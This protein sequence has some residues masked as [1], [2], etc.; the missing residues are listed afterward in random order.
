M[1]AKCHVIGEPPRYKPRTDSHRDHPSATTAGALVMIRR[2]REP[3]RFRA[4]GRAQVR[5]HGLLEHFE[6]GWQRY[7]LVENI[8]LGGARVAVDEPLGCNDGVMLSF[9]APTLWDPLHLRARIA[10]V[11]SNAA[12]APDGSSEKDAFWSQEPQRAGLAFDHRSRESL[13]RLCEFLVALGP[14]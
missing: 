4:H 5:L 9:T 14:E 12:S 3:T 8:G 2:A 6:A 11:G 1:A 7:A 13:F 10:W